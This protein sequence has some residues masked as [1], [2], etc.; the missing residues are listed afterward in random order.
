MTTNINSR[1][2]DDED[3]FDGEET[4]GAEYQDESIVEGTVPIAL[5]SY[6][7]NVVNISPEKLSVFELKRKHDKNPPMIKLDPDFQRNSVWT[8]KQKS[9]LIES[10]LMGIPLPLIYVKEDD[11]GVYIIV[12][13]RQRLTTLFQF[14]D[15]EFALHGLT[16]LKEL[17]GLFFSN[18]S[19]NHTQFNHCLTQIQQN[20]IEDC[21]LTLHVIKPPT[22]DRV[23]F[24]LFDRVNRGGTRLNNQEM[25][26]ALY[27]GP[28]TKLLSKLVAFESFRKVTEGAIKS[29]R[30]KDKYLVLRL[31]AFHL[32]YQKKLTTVKEKGQPLVEYRSDIEDFLGKTMLFLNSQAG[33]EFCANFPR[34]FDM[35]MTLCLDVL[36]AGCFKRPKN[37]SGVNRRRLNM[38]LFETIACSM[39][40]VVENLTVKQRDISPEAIKNGYANLFKIEEFNESTTYAIDSRQNVERRFGMAIKMIMEVF[41][42]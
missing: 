19:K 41:N 31:V 2:P 1:A 38:A 23:T 15:H 36:D 14:M 25:R 30:M 11:K 24:D 21:Q 10:I 20:K 7:D 17:N 3:S 39:L 42:A 40:E 32:W 9:E 4:L 27:Q 6:P 35:T 34:K 26:N 12:D 22:Q 37:A 33:S 5:A 28:A 16:A 8:H 29:E 13:G 18:E